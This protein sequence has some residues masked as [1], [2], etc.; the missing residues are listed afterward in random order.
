MNEELQ[1]LHNLDKMMAMLDNGECIQE[2][3]MV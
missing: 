3:E 1:V 2:V